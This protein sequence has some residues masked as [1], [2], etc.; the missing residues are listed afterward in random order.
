MF[1]L[2]LWHSVGLVLTRLE[3][4]VLEKEVMERE[5]YSRFVV[6]LNEKKAKIRGLQGTLHHLQQTQEER[7][8]AEGCGFLSVWIS[9]H[10]CHFTA[11]F[12]IAGV[13]T[14]L[15]LC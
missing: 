14:L 6:L 3:Q 15:D 4:Q 10:G 7:E 9:Q 5:L 12:P 2:A 8:H 13:C 11:Y 1:K